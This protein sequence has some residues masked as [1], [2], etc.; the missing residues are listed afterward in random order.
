MLF[1][2]EAENEYH[3]NVKGSFI[4]KNLW[5]KVKDEKTFSTLFHVEMDNLIKSEKMSDR[6]IDRQMDGWIY[7]QIVE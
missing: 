2:G 6:Q 7:R 3:F 1:K 4:N 5:V